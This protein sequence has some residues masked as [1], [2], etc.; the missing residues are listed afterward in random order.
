MI[1]AILFDL[2]GTL[3]DSAPDLVATLNWLRLKNNLPELPFS[4]MRNCAGRGAVGL[5]KAGM[6]EVNPE[7]L[8][9]W[10]LEFLD[11]YQQSSLERSGLFEGVRDLLGELDRC[12]LPWGIVTNKPEYLTIPIVEA[13]GLSASLGCLVCGDTLEKRKPHPAPLLLACEQLGVEPMNT[14]YVGDDVRDLQAGHAAHTEVCA[15]LYGYGYEELARPEHFEL[16]QNAIRIQHPN[17]L[18][19]YLELTPGVPGPILR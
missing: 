2:D 1:R 17:E 14:L 9:S 5:L 6:P 16:L 3:L 7:T 10:R 19:G 11:R 8:E 15:A 4:E 18:T 12:H 13:F